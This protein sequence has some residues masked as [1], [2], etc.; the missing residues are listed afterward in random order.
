MSGS[1]RPVRHDPASIRRLLTDRERSGESYA[2]LSRR[3]GVPVGTLAWW[4]HRER[5]RGSGGASAFVEL[6]V[7]DAVPSPPSESNRGFTVLVGT[8]RRVRE[9]VVPP[10]FDADEL[11]KLVAILEDEPC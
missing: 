9:I 4:A 3:S 7:K 5:Q 11:R 2:S 6:R 8:E 1:G 10:G